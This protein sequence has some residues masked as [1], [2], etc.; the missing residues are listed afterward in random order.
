MEEITL[1]NKNMIAELKMLVPNL[2]VTE[3]DDGYLMRVSAN[4]QYEKEIEIVCF[5]N[6][7]AQI[8]YFENYSEEIKQKFIDILHKYNWKTDF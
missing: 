5:Y 3:K 8:D 2:E 7:Y 1:K 6:K 4:S